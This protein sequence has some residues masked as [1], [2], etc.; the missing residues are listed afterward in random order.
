MTGAGFPLGVKLA[1][2]E[3]GGAAASAGISE[4]A[5]SM[6]G[7]LGG[8]ITGALLIPLLGIQGTCNLLALLSLATLLPLA[9]A[10]W[11]PA[12]IEP[13]VSST[14]STSTWELRSVGKIALPSRRDG[15]M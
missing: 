11:V 9:Y 4:A 3:L 10:R 5:D 15:R 2:A 14:T 7:A 6:G 13:L 1:Q 12:R 8:L